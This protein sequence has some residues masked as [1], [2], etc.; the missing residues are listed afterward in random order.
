M[1]SIFLVDAFAR[2]PF[3]GNPAGV[4]PLE[5]WPEDT[6]MQ[7]VALE[8]NQAETAF[9]VPEGDGFRLRWFTPTV[10]VDLCGHATLATAHV[11]MTER[12]HEGEIVFQTRSGPLTCRREKDLITMDFPSEAPWPEPLPTAI[13][14]LSP[15]WTGRNRMDWFVEVGSV[16]EVVG[17]APSFSAIAVLGLRGLIVTAAGDGDQD[18]TSRCFFPQSGVDEDPVTGSAHCA[19]APYWQERLGRDALVGFQAS[20]RGGI[21]RCGVSGGRVLLQGKAFTTMQGNLR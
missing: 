11:L 10:E 5:A 16:A 7:N 20:K 9:F 6:W 2:G 8:M 15:V 3:T 19:L 21:V 17:F 1:P 12:D 4:V 13:P 14:G 18:F